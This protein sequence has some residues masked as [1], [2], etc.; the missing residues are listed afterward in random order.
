[1]KYMRITTVL[2]GLLM[3]SF[4]SF[5]Q[6]LVTGTIKDVSGTPIPG[7]NILEKN[8]ITY[9]KYYKIFLHSHWHDVISNVTLYAFFKF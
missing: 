4:S 1:M 8:Q 9:H 5:G 3:L 2:I 7:C 6:N